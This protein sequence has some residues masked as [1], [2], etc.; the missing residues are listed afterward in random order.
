MRALENDPRAFALIM[1]MV[2]KGFLGAVGALK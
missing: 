2:A 1:K